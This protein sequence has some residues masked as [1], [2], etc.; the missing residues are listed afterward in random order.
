MPVVPHSNSS[1]GFPPSHLHSTPPVPMTMTFAPS[2]HRW[3]GHPD[4][5]P[6]TSGFPPTN[7]PHLHSSA[8]QPG[9]GLSP[10]LAHCWLA[11]TLQ[12]MMAAPKCP[13]PSSFGKSR[14]FARGFNGAVFDLSCLQGRSAGRPLL[15]QASGTGHSLIS[16]GPVSSVQSRAGPL[17]FVA[18]TFVANELALMPGRSPLCLT[19]SPISPGSL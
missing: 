2:C 1:T 15:G 16:H 4:L 19:K 6:V 3:L 5:A 9:C 8:R 10:T 14:V 13:W 18:D 17:S 7:N 11:G 12:S